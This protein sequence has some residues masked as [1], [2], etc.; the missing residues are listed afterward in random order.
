MILTSNRGWLFNNI[1]LRIHVIDIERKNRLL[2][3]CY[4]PVTSA[5]F[6]AFFFFFLAAAIN[7]INEANKAGGTHH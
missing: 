5:I 7:I 6:L 4:E 1:Y 3:V 2:K